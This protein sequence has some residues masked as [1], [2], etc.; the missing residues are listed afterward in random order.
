VTD[1]LPAAADGVPATAAEARA[2]LERLARSVL[3]RPPASGAALER[4]IEGIMAAAD[5]YWHAPEEMPRPGARVCLDGAIADRETACRH[6]FSL[7]SDVRKWIVLTTDPAR[8]TCA[9]C[10]RSKLYKQVTGD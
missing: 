4:A 1:R 2:G 9:A 6:H 8:V 7:G 3:Q 10:K 5:D